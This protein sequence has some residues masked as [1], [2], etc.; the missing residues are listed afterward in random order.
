MTP[1]NFFSIPVLVESF[2]GRN[3]RDLASFSTLA[4]VYAHEIIVVR[5]FARVYI[6]KIFIK[7][8]APLTP[9][10]RIKTDQ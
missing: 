1:C 4:K 8:K 7:H 2:A 3:F 5:P 10:N 9:V 6:R